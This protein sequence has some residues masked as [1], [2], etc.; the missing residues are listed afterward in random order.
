MLIKVDVESDL[1]AQIEKLVKDAKYSD[2]YQFIK[3]AINNQLQE[4]KG[5]SLEIKQKTQSRSLT[6]TIQRLTDE[7][8]M[9]LAK[10]QSD[11]PLEESEIASLQSPLIWSFYTRFFP[12][13]VVV[14][15]L[16][17]MITADRTWLNLKDAQEEAFNF[18]E[19]IA[20]VLKAHE[21]ENNLPRNEKLSTGLPLP[22]SELD[23][24]RGVRIRRKKEAKLLASKIRFQKQFV[25]KHINKDPPNFNG[26]CFI[27]GLMRIKFED[28]KCLVTLSEKGSEFALMENPILDNEDFSHSF[29]DEEIQ[30]IKNEI[31]PKFDLENKIIQKIS[32]KV[33]EKNLTSNDVDEI[34]RDEK[35]KYYSKEEISSKQ[36][37]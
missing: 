20:D 17:M 13:K 5:G 32:E 24:I 33:K 1:Y 4:E 10:L 37:E 28:S 14:R 7:A 23:G 34:F 21:D 11:I 30:F 26:A 25:G 19:N 6:S 8:S 18:A 9:Q 15:K 27:M 35:L 3:V 29:S 2:F 31:I 16:A 12:I 22:Q 36:K